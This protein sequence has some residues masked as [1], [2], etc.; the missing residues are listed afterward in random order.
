MNV[1]STFVEDSLDTHE[2]LMPLSDES[3]DS[4]YRFGDLCTTQD[5]ITS[6]HYWRECSKLGH[7]PSAKLD[8]SNEI[9]ACTNCSCEIF[10]S[11][12]GFGW[13]DETTCENPLEEPEL[14]SPKGSGEESVSS[15]NIAL[16]EA[17]GSHDPSYD[18]VEEFFEGCRFS[19]LEE[20]V[21]HPLNILHC[22]D[23]LSISCKL[24]GKFTSLILSKV[25]GTLGDVYNPSSN[26]SSDGGN[27]M[28]DSLDTS[29]NTVEPSPLSS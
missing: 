23:F 10:A 15:I 2:D 11:A 5:S 9:I 7:D 6:G 25:P 19:D 1:D 12:W 26:A 3:E 8:S 28:N 27:F 16:W 21:N 20:F 17:K 18:P 22:E 24:S 4:A 13:F 29:Y 14:P